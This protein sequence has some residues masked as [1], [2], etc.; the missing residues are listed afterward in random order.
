MFSHRHLRQPL[1]ASNIS[2]SFA[3]SA[4]K[5][6]TVVFTVLTVLVDGALVRLEEALAVDWS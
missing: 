6:W 3:V 2:R 1:W 5:R 4:A